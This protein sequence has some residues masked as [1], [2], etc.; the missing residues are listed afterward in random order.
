MLILSSGWLLYFNVNQSELNSWNA[1]SIQTLSMDSGFYEPY[2]IY[3]SEKERSS[4]GAATTG[5]DFY[6]GAEIKITE[7]NRSQSVSV[8]T[9]H[10][11][12]F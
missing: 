10:I 12:G 11:L 4:V 7:F 6:P 3:R 9:Q 5:V 1:M 2:C 8:D